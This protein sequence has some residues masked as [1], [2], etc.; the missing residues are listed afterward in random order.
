[1]LSLMEKASTKGQRPETKAI[2][3]VR[4]KTICI[5]TKVNTGLS[6]IGM[7]IVYGLTRL[8]VV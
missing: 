5:E 6:D 1:M 8:A 2:V 3:K 7:I 4:T